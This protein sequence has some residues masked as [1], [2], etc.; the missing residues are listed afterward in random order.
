MVGRAWAW[1][2]GGRASA[3]HGCWPRPLVKMRTSRQPALCNVA[4]AAASVQ[5]VL[6]P[7]MSQAVGGA[8]SAAR[9]LASRETTRPKEARPPG[10]Q[11]NGRFSGC[12][13]FLTRAT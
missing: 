6:Q 4:T 1:E 2:V 7:L 8:S 9:T 3:T 12:A 11:A 5:D 10:R 13:S